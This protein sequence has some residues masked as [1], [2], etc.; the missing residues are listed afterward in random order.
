MGYKPILSLFILLKMNPVL[1]GWDDVTQ[2]GALGPRP[3]GSGSQKKEN[4]RLN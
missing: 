1:L 4:S 2:F 3:E